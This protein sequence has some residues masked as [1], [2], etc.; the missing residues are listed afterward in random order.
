[1][2]YRSDVGFACD[3]IIKDVIEAVTEWD[4]EF[5]EMIGY[6]EDLSG[7]DHGRW[8]F[9]DIKW[10]EGYEDVQIIENIMVMCDNVDI[11]GLAYDSYGFIRLG[12][13]MED[14]EMKGDTSAFDLYV[15]RSIDI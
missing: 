14:V 1:M 7:D 10:Y 4:K 9:E 2:G 15:N 11:S 6:A 8:R 5:K 13:E 12:E 3:P